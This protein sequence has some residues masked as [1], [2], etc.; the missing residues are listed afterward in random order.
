MRRILGCIGITVLGGL[1]AAPIGVNARLGLSNR[2]SLELDGKSVGFLRSVDGGGV[3]A[4]V[5][6]FREGG[7][8]VCTA[9]KSIGGPKYEDLVI[10][11]GLDLAPDFYEWISDFLECQNDPTDGA[12]VAVDVFGKNRGELNFHDALISEV[13]FPALDAASKD[14][15]FLTVKVTPES[16]EFE[17][18]DGS[19]VPVPVA[20]GTKLWQAS[21]FRVQVGG[22]PC[23]RVSKVEGFTVKQAI[24]RFQSGDSDQV[25]LVPGNLELPNL[26]FT[27][28]SVD[29]PAWE[30]FFEDFVVQG[31]NGSGAELEGSIVYLDAT[32]AE[33]AR[34]ELHGVGIFR[35]DHFAPSDPTAVGKF[36][37]ELYVEGMEFVRSGP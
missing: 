17:A 37:V 9:Q 14:P 12:V 34:V 22:L 29:L 24:T 27:I 15:A 35:L 25:E 16:T 36:T 8:G 20:K 23:S 18:G 6:E 3:S 28:S 21:N 13:G 1:L 10:E 32:Q 30:D 5:I 11:A 33:L 19:L 26:T 4:D 7:E 31:N 2:F